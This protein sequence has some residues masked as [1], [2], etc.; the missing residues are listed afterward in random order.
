MLLEKE[1]PGHLLDCPEDMVACR[2]GAQVTRGGARQATLSVMEAPG[3]LLIIRIIRIVGLSAVVVV[4]SEVVEGLES[5]G[6]HI[7]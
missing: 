5:R 4:P 6:C 2:G 7:R 3:N 1:R